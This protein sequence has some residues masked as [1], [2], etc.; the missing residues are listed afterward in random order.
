MQRFDWAQAV[1]PTLISLVCKS[2]GDVPASTHSKVAPLLAR[3]LEVAGGPPV[4]ETTLSPNDMDRLAQGI[5]YDALREV[6]AADAVSHA[7]LGTTVVKSEHRLLTSQLHAAPLVHVNWGTEA[8]I[9][10]LPGVG[11]QIAKRVVAERLAGGMFKGPKDLAERVDGIGEKI[12]ISIMRCLR[13]GHRPTLRPTP[14][15]LSGWLTMLIKKT[16]QPA[17]DGLVSVLTHAAVTLAGNTRLRWHGDKSYMTE[18]S[19]TPHTCKAIGIVRGTDY[20]KWLLQ[21]I[22]SV[23]KNISMAMFHVAMPESD[24]P[25]RKLIDALIA[26]QVRGVNVRVL[27]DRDRPEDP[28][29]STIINAAARTALL[30]GGVAVR[31]DAPERLLHSKFLIFDGMHVVIG[32]HNWS[33][34]SYFQY[35]DLTLVLESEQLAAQLL[36]RFE[37]LWSRSS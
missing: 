37:E 35:D 3:L 26:A 22:P 30:A 9:A 23:T 21:A 11:P 32:S 13:F 16:G 24:H 18:P 10:A 19:G 34:G 12:A 2:A 15:E 29:G 5:L 28:Y 14:R 20:Y 27:L 25:T 31:M 1:S 4:C 17:A 7:D 33:A 6:Y 8:E 36:Q